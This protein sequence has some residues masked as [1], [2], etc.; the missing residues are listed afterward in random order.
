[1]LKRDDPFTPQTRRGKR[2][3]DH[4]SPAVKTPLRNMHSAENVAVNMTPIVN[5][6]I[7]DNRHKQEQRQKRAQLV[8]KKSSAELLSPAPGISPRAAPVLVNSPALRHSPSLSTLNTTGQKMS[9][10]QMTRSFDEWMRIAADNKINAK[11]TWNFALIDYFSELT[12]L[13]DTDDSINFQKASCTLDGC[14]KIYSSRVDAV[15]DE[16]SK[17]L[18]GLNE[19]DEKTIDEESDAED[20]GNASSK[21]QTLRKT[22]PPGATLEKN[23]ENLKGKL[24]MDGATIDPLFKKTCA[25]FDEASGGTLLFNLT[26]DHQSRVIFDTSTA[27]YM[28]VNY[29]DYDEQTID[30]VNAELIVNEFGGQLIDFEDKQLTTTLSNY[31]FLNYTDNFGIHDRLAASLE[32]L[33]VA[34]VEQHLDDQ[35]NPFGEDAIVEPSQHQKFDYFD[36][37]EDGIEDGNHVTVEE[38]EYDPEGEGFGFGQSGASD[39]FA[40]LEGTSRMKTTW[41]G[42]EHWKIKRV[43]RTTASSS[44]SSQSVKPVKRAMEI[45][46]LAVDVDLEQLLAKPSTALTVNLADT[47]VTTLPD[48]L[49]ITSDLFTKLFLKPSWRFSRVQSVER[50]DCSEQRYEPVEFIPVEPVDTVHDDTIDGTVD[51]IMDVDL[52]QNLLSINQ[53]QPTDQVS[54]NYTRRAKRVDVHHLKETIWKTITS[55]DET[56]TLSSIVDALPALYQGQADKADISIQ[57]AFICLLHLA[58]EHGL[59]IEERGD[60]D[61]TVRRC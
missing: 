23:P 30:Y 20:A 7:S 40:F 9:I 27:E 52:S 15:V 41:A 11:N 47:T 25:E 55:K 8:K 61:L 4:A 48:D 32:K 12:F 56:T 22:R 18:N 17:L 2:V 19:R 43:A 37:V 29:G 46:F 6:E 10:E 50:Q 3:K 33:T 57:F 54:V 35:V 59:R 58:N 16:T 1:M 28:S 38:Y 24:E 44:Q 5:H 49:H 13:K 42:T 53:T 36:T 51:D 60:G 34:P 14:V 21:A 39:A 31:S 26:I 45:D